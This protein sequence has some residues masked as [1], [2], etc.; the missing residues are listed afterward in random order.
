M[1]GQAM[2]ALSRP[3]ERRVEAEMAEVVEVEAEAEAEV[4]VAV[5]VPEAVAQRMG[6][7]ATWEARAA[8]T[9]EAM[10][11]WVAQGVAAAVMAMEQAC[12][13]MKWLSPVLWMRRCKLAWTS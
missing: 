2:A 12:H 4:E 8:A 13:F 11:M 6:K 10:R 3:Q 1:C 7:V 9:V 5:A